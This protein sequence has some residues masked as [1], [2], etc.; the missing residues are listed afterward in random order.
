MTSCFDRESLLFTTARMIIANWSLFKRSD[1]Q[2]SHCVSAP[3]TKRVT[4]LA[5]GSPN[6]APFKCSNRRPLG[7][8]MASWIKFKSHNA[9]CIMDIDHLRGPTLSLW[10][11]LG[12]GD[13]FFLHPFP[14]FAEYLFLA[15]K[16]PKLTTT[17]SVLVLN[18]T[19]GTK[20]AFSVH[21]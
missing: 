11:L 4:V 21:S 15:A 19:R 8:D 9:C 6:W 10:P 13:G 12:V 1:H 20:D 2:T 7:V 18:N 14:V 17:R 3:I 16:A 5:L